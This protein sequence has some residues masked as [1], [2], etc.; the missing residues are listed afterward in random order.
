VQVLFAGRVLHVSLRAN[1]ERRRRR[2]KREAGR[3]GKR[4]AALP[5]C[6]FFIRATAFSGQTERTRRAMQV[7]RS[8]CGLK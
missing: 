5:V 6:G 4:E 8:T 3:R 7:Y 1:R 2:R